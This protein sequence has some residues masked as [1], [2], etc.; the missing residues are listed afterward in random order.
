IDM[1]GLNG[2][3]LAET[4][5]APTQF[6]FVTAHA[7]FALQAFEL[8]A[9]D[10]LLKPYDQARLNDVVA[11]IRERQGAVPR[12]L[13]LDDGARILMLEES[14]IDWIGA[15]GNYVEVHGGGKTVLARTT[16]E[17]MAAQLP[18]FLRINRSALVRRGA[19]AELR[20]RPHGEFLVTL[21]DGTALMWTRRFRGPLVP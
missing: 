9:C 5:A 20:K 6:V 12:R 8:H 11:Q 19:I 16:M 1:P 14:A 18:D 17:A 10:Y 7:A 21:G 4:I 13:A 2:L 15:A 3:E